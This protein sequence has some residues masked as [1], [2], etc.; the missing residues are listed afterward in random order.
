MPKEFVN[1]HEAPAAIGIYSQ[2]IRSGQ[3]VYLSGQ[4][5]LLPESMEIATGIENQIRQV[6]NNI[7]AV[8]RASGGNMDQI[9]KLNIY[10]TDMTHFALV[11]QIM[12]EFFNKPYPARAALGVAELPKNVAVEMD[13][14]LD[15]SIK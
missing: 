4:I 5:P 9:V 10:L 14:I 1:T 7:D 11:N 2:A 8:V 12:A 15:L 6:F 3:I 13:G